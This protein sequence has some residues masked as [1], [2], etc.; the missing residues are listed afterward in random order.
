MATR[1]TNEI[2]FVADFIPANK[3]VARVVEF[4]LKAYN[5]VPATL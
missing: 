4:K 1:S 3:V 5:Y 2:K